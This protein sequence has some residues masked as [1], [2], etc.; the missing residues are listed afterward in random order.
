MA[1]IERWESVKNDPSICKRLQKAHDVMHDYHF[2]EE[3][4]KH[5]RC[6]PCEIEGLCGI[7]N[8]VLGTDNDVEYGKQM[9]EYLDIKLDPKTIKKNIENWNE[10]LN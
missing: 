10:L 4:L 7:R 2:P 8:I 5:Y 6:I 9:L 3:V 1:Y